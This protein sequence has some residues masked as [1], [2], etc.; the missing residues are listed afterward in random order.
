MYFSLAVCPEHGYL[1]GKIRIKKA[2]GD[3]VFAVK[4]L[5]LT[6]EEGA[7]FVVNKKEELRKKRAERS[8]AKRL[9]QRE[10]A[11]AGKTRKKKGKKA[12]KERGIPNP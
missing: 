8:R 5:K 10:E 2:D 12:K 3:R 1:K 4:T 6:D 7:A 11:A 9:R